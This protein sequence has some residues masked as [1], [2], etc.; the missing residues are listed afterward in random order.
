MKRIHRAIRPTL[1]T[2]DEFFLY[3]I[4]YIKDGVTV[5]IV[6][7]TIHIVDKDGV[8]GENILPPEMVKTDDNLSAMFTIL[9]ADNVLKEDP[10]DDN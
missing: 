9:V 10:A 5:D 2:K 7:T 4:E 8:V 1:T 6:G 3:H